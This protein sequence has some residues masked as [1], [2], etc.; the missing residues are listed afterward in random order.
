MVRELGKSMQA[1]GHDDDEVSQ[2][3]MNNSKTNLFDSF[4]GTYGDKNTG[5]WPSGLSV[6]Q[7]PGRP[8]FVPRLSHTKDSK[9]GT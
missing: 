9:N 6:R 1:A 2:S 3:N 7:S 5:H 8:G 4:M